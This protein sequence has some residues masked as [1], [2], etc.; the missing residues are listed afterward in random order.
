MDK[1]GRESILSFIFVVGLLVSVGS[2]YFKYIL[3]NDYEILVL[4]NE[5]IQ[6]FLSQ[7][8]SEVTEDYPSGD[9]VLQEID[10]KIPVD[11]TASST[12]EREVQ[13]PIEVLK[14]P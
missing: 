1:K 11:E 8:D 3:K 14:T 12:E 9:A 10:G 7:N 2:L 13:E 4:S 5:E 6:D